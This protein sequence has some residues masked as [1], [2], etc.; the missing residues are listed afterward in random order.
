M[1]ELINNLEQMK[2][3]VREIYVYSG[4]LNSIKEAES[5]GI[6]MNES[7]KNLISNSITTLTN[8]LRI[9]NNSLPN[10]LN[11]INLYTPLKNTIE[12]NNLSKIKYKTSNKQNTVLVHKKEKVNYI[13]NLAKSRNS[14]TLLKDP[15]DN[16]YKRKVNPYTKIS[17]KFF[18]NYSRNLV[19][20]GYFKKLN[21]NLRKISSNYIVTSY[22]SMILFTTLL[23]FVAGLLFYIV[24]LFFDISLAYPFISRV[25]G[26]VYIRLLTKLWALFVFPL[27][28]GALFYLYPSSEAKS[29]GNRINQ[30]LPFVAIHMSAV[31]SSGVEPIKIFEILIKGGD[32]KYSN[33]EFKKL[34][35]L[36]NLHGED[37]V[38]ALRKISHSTSSAKLR[39]LL[40]GLSVT[41]TSGG[42]LGEYLSKHAE[43]MLFD[44]RIEREKYNK[45]SETFMDIYISVAIAAPM[46]FLMIFVII[47]STGMTILGLTTDLLSLLIIFV[48]VLINVFFLIYLNL[49]QPTI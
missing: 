43:N 24:M 39:D 28:A 45:I 17:N 34:M 37:I 14:I 5:R 18:R 9:L 7:Q 12:T 20:K 30:E 35:N 26:S 29:L 4:K 23:A 41:I 1:S 31:A 32:Y 19:S 27:I 44:Y 2:E 46:I 8:Q 21:R 48:V 3:I 49:K 10:T 16:I 25:E 22:V 42:D 40:N 38:N 36:I 13:D 47:G 33:V 15:S 6:R 11:H